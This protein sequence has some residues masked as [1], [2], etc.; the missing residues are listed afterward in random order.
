MCMDVSNLNLN[1]GNY[2]GT[3][4]L[5]ILECY[6]NRR[7]CKELSAK[8]STSWLPRY[9]WNSNVEPEVASKLACTHWKLSSSYLEPLMHIRNIFKWKFGSS[10]QK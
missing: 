6:L 2:I 8:T 1:Y 3:S 5:S 10:A 4:Y 9:R 7:I